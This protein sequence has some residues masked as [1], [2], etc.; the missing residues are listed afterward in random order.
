MSLRL[1]QLSMR[2]ASLKEEKRLVKRGL[3]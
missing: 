2:L 3:L 1:R